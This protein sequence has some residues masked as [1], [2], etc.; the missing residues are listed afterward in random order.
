MDTPC[1]GLNIKQLRREQG[2]TQ[3]ELAWHLHVSVQAV[4]KWERGGSC[5]D[6][7]LLQPMAR[8]FKVSIDRLF[9]EKNDSL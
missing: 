9:E 5:P 8:L 3:R 2:M 6:I 4:S 7:S 1:L